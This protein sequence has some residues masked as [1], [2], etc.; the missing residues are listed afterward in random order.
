M[1]RPSGRNRSKATRPR[2]K[3]AVK[4]A[5]TRGIAD[6]GRVALLVGTRK[7]AFIYYGDAS[8]ARWTLD[9]PH[10]LGEIV[11]HIVLDPRDRTTMLM[12]ARTGHLG[13]TIFRSTDFGRTWIEAK[14]PPAFPKAAPGGNGRAV[15]Y[16]FWLSP[17]HRTEPDAWY[18]GTSP[19]A[20]FRSDD[21]GATWHGMEGFN[22]HPMYAKWNRPGEGAP[23]G[24]QLSWVNVDPRNAAHLYLVSSNGGAFE[25]VDRGISW[26]PLNK[27]VEAN[28]MPDPYPEYGQDVHCLR[29]H[30]ARPDRLYQQ[31]HCG[32]YRLD[33]PSEQW[34]RIGN[35]MPRDIG[36]IGF[37]IVVHPRD[38]NTAWVFPMDGTTV[39]PR[40]S[41]DGKPA[42]YCTTDAGRHWTRQDRG[43]PREHAWYTVK[44]QAFCADECDPVGLYFG[45][46]SGELWMS[47]NAGKSW[48]QIAAHLPHIYSV[49]AAALG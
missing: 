45:T 15:D 24:P 7:G 28:F 9:G 2:G 43:L 18:A 11:N 25:T 33:R 5:A 23:D 35:N 29:M 42:V 27:N 30:P 22:D 19:P 4:S 12:A 49:E 38:P 41:P 8:R 44:R 37:G 47:P 16:T 46:T 3:R 40:T 17:A 34:V 10:R 14:E 31:N 39:W 26:R 21:G 1:N 13:P 32:I 6:R 48:R 20:L 36:D